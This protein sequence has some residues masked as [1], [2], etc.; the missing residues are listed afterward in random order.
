[1]KTPVHSEPSLASPR[2]APALGEDTV[3]VLASFVDTAELERLETEGVIRMAR[4]VERT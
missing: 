1:M 3:D 2:R 4:P